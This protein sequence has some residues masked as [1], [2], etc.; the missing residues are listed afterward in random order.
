MV[1]KKDI[2]TNIPKYIDYENSRAAGYMPLLIYSSAG[3][4]LTSTPKTHGWHR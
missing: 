1:H 2:R 4:V 3:L